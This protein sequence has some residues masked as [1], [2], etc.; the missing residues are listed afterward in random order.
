[1]IPI[2]HR[3]SGREK[4][5]LAWVGES[6]P[7]R[8]IWKANGTAGT[9]SAAMEGYQVCGAARLRPPGLF[10][11]ADG[12]KRVLQTGDCMYLRSD[13]VVLAPG[14]KNEVACR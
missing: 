2:F 8:L 13:H 12:R 7:Q 3:W 5:R 6:S 4:V 14:P 11:S 9:I 1:M 10:I